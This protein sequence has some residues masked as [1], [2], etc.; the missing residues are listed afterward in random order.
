MMKTP[1]SLLI[2]LTTLL[3]LS[4]SAQIGPN[5]PYYPYE[6]NYPDYPY[7]GGYDNP[8]SPI[9]LTDGNPL[10]TVAQAAAVSAFEAAIVDPEG[11]EDEGFTPEEVAEGATEAAQQTA[12]GAFS[13]GAEFGAGSYEIGDVDADMY[14]LSIPYSMELGERAKLFLTAPLSITT[15]QDVLATWDNTGTLQ[16]DDAQ[17]YGGGL[18]AAYTR[19]IFIKKDDVP[20][21]WNLTPSAGIFLRESSDLDLGSWVFNVGLSSSFAYQFAPGWV[22]NIGNSISYSLST[23]SSDYPDPE[24]ENQQVL[25][26]GLQLIRMT[27]RWTFNAYAVDT[28]MLQNSYVDGYQ[29]YALGAAFKVTRTRSL[30]ATIICD[31]GNNY[32]SIRGTL[33]TTWKF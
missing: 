33:G 23:A 6:P 3:P 28:Q 32:N 1:P 12:S 5:D 10:A 2:T 19:R 16:L 8:E 25:I 9:G 15:L 13:L 14:T 20:Y 21:R 17:I 31:N 7:E 30:R 24:R 22:I 4:L 11:L 27:G 26:N 29:T 18:N